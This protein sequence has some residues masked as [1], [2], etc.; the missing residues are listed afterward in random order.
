SDEAGILVGDVLTLVG[1]TP[2]KD[3]DSLR[4]ALEAQQPGSSVPL[5]LIRRGAPLF[6]GLRLPE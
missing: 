6:I 2:V 5:R 4:E 3:L 1:S